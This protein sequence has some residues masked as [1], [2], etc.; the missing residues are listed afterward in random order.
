MSTARCTH[1]FYQGIQLLSLN[2]NFVEFKS[3]CRKK[4]A[5]LRCRQRWR[6]TKR[7]VVRLG[8]RPTPHVVWFCARV[9][10]VDF[11]LLCILEFRFISAHWKAKGSIGNRLYLCDWCH[12]TRPCVHCSKKPGV[13]PASK[14]YWTCSSVHA[15]GKCNC[16]AKFLVFAAI[17]EKSPFHW[18]RFDSAPSLRKLCWSI[19]WPHT[20]DL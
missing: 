9:V 3:H 13:G 16:F 1:V 14:W 11:F 8:K 6:R 15:C 4:L 7:N 10:Y 17:H 18:S 12:W 20:K 2:C 19:E 5:R